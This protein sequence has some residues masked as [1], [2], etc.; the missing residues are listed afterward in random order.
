VNFTELIKMKYR[1]ER[2]TTK[3]YVFCSHQGV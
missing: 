2:E 1:T 3:Q